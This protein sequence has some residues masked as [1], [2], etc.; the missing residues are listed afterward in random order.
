M[1]AP[2]FYES[3]PQARPAFFLKPRLRRGGMS[4]LFMISG[5]FRP[6][7]FFMRAKSAGKGALRARRPNI[8]ALGGKTGYT[9]HI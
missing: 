2:G 4:C 8:L 1:P 9:N 5:R 6:E 3:R 7:I